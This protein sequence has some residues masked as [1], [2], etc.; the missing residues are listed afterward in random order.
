MAGRT[1][2]DRRATL[3]RGRIR[4]RDSRAE[5]AGGRGASG[6]RRQLGARGQTGLAGT[7]QSRAARPVDNVR[8]L[9]FDGFILEMLGAGLGCALF[10]VAR[11][12][13]MDGV[14]PDD[15]GTLEVANLNAGLFARMPVSK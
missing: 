6:Q 11:G 12:F 3:V 13:F 5:G 14:T 10:P 1:S 9:F 2:A 8:R 7:R 4:T 15:L